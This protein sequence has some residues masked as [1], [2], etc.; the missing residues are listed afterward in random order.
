MI[1]QNVPS[2]VS[3]PR[4]NSLVAAKVG[5][6]EASADLQAIQNLSTRGMRGG[7]SAQKRQLL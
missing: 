5:P 6:G 7:I 2:A 1:V 4:D 3:V